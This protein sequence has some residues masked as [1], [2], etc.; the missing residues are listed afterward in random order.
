MGVKW[1]GEIPEYGGLWR[2]VQLLASGWK[3]FV[4]SPMFPAYITTENGFSVIIESL[5]DYYPPPPITDPV[6]NHSRQCT[7]S[8]YLHNRTTT[9]VH[10]N[11]KRSSHYHPPPPLSSPSH[12]AFLA[13][14]L[15]T[16]PTV[17]NPNITTR[18]PIITFTSRHIYIL[19]KNRH[20]KV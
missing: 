4:S 8:S 5:K 19:I 2:W 6:K 13:P 17:H 18:N 9:H 16:T 3:E 15:T 10:P 1:S 12:T 11:A 20:R 14:P 7:P